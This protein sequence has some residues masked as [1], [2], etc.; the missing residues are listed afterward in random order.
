MSSEQPSIAA[1]QQKIEEQSAQL[2]ALAERVNKLESKVPVPKWF[3]NE[4]GQGVLGQMN[5]L[6]GTV[7]FWR[8]LAVTLRI[9]G[10]RKAGS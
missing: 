4:F 2:A 7:D 3:E 10:Y 1:L 8:S 6:S 5:D 9:I